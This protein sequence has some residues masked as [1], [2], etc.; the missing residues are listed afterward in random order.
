MS[1]TRRTLRSATTSISKLKVLPSPVVMDTIGRADFLAH[2][3]DLP[4]THDDKIDDAR[5]SDRD[6]GLWLSRDGQIFSQCKQLPLTHDD[7]E[8]CIIRPEVFDKGRNIGL[9]LRAALRHRL[10]GQGEAAD[11]LCRRTGGCARCRHGKR[12]IAFPSLSRREVQV[13][14]NL[15]GAK[16]TTAGPIS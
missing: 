12:G 5:I 13:G 9:A 7:F 10:Q 3:A 14:Q 16:G 6:D 11:C 8:G 1:W 4:G 15:D 2:Q